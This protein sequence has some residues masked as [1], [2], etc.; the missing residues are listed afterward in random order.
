[1]PIDECFKVYRSTLSSNII[2]GDLNLPK[3]EW[4]NLSGVDDQVHK[5]LSLIHI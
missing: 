5:P 3:I 4:F 1:M 2:V